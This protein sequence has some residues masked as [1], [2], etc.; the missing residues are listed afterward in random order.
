RTGRWFGRAAQTL[1]ARLRP[2]TAGGAA[3]ARIGTDVP[4]AIFGWVAGASSFGLGRYLAGTCL[5]LVPAG[6]A[7]WAV[8]HLV[9][10]LSESGGAPR[11][12]GTVA[13]S[14][15]CGLAHAF[16]AR[17]LRASQPL[18]RSPDGPL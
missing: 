8:A 5:A 13:L 7:L 2:R 12:A 15:A 10:G 1:A 16:A 3:R 9:A 11:L 18:G 4:F 14:A 6:L 17:R